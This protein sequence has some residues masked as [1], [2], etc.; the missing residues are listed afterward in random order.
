MIHVEW[1]VL[2]FKCDEF[3]FIPMTDRCTCSWQDFSEKTMNSHISVYQSEFWLSIWWKLDLLAYVARQLSIKSDKKH[4]QSVLMKIWDISKYRYFLPAIWN[5]FCLHNPCFTKCHYT[6]GNAKTSENR[7]D[8]RSF[9][10]KSSLKSLMVVMS[11]LSSAACYL[12]YFH[13]DTA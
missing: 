1:Y 8:H 2:I 4:T 12:V 6:H 5:M 3:C 10:C 13:S 11:V 7:D 9:F